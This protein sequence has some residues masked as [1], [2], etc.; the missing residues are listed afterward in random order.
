MKIERN[1][2]CP[3][4]SGQ[5]FKKCHLG[6]E[7][8]LQT[9][10]PDEVSEEDSRRVTSLPGVEY[11]CIKQIIDGLDIEELTG[12]KLGIKFIDLRAYAKLT[13]LGSKM[14]EEDAS[15]G[16][17]VFVNIY[18]TEKTDPNNIY[19][20]VSPNITESVLIHQTA[21][22]LDYLKGSGLMP[23]LGKALSMELQVPVEH[24]EHPH[25]FGYWLHYLHE[26]FNTKFDADDT[27]VHYLFEN[28]KL[29]KAEE[30]KDQDG[31]LISEKSKNILEFLHKNSAVINDLIRECDGYI[32]AQTDK[33]R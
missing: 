25:E 24:L 5:K 4:G 12:S 22:A 1:A 33:N 16:G 23:G 15:G 14:A 26:T 17:S 18:R 32:G 7:D 30:I 21:H 29:L 28:E 10:K 27:I 13:K 3:C 8:E 19:I 6:K 9:T 11:G 20:A 31:D 2:P